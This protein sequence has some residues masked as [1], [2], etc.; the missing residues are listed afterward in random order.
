M[1][2]RTRLPVSARPRENH[3][4]TSLPM[5]PALL[6]WGGHSCLP[7]LIFCALFTRAEEKQVPKENQGLPL[8]LHLDFNT[9]DAATRNLTFTDKAAW[10][11]VEDDVNGKKQNVLALVQQSDY[12]PPVRSPVNIAWINDLKVSSFVIEIKCRITKEKIPHRDLCFEFGGVDASHFLYAHMAQEEDKIHN[13]IHLVNGKDREPV[14]VKRSTG[15]PWDEKYHVVKITRDE[16]GAANVYFDD[17]LMMTTDRKDLP[18]GKLGFGSF[19]DI[20]NFAEVTVWG[21]KTE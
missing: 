20:G 4:Q 9:G 15:T 2:K 21:K 5:P 3:G 17:H 7:F 10:K 19:D 1:G 6:R 14:T 11:I 8:L 18:A 12:K 13:Q 16:S